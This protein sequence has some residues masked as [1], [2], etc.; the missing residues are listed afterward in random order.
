MPG[1]YIHMDVARKALDDLA[2]NASVAPIFSSQGTR[3]RPNP[4]HRAGQ[5][6]LRR[7]R[8]D[9][10][11]H[12]LPVARLQAAI[13]ADDMETRLHHY[14]SIPELGRHLPSALLMSDGADGN[15]AAN[16]ENALT[17]GLKDTI[18]TIVAE[19]S[20]LL[21]DFILNLILS[22]M[23]SSGCF[24]WPAGG[25][26]RADVLL[27]RHVPLSRDQPVRSRALATRQQPSD[28]SK[29]DRITAASR[30]SRW[31][32][33][34]HI[35]TDVTGHA[36]VNQKVGGPYR[37]HWQRHHLVENHLDSQVYSAEHGA[38]PI[39]DQMANAALHLWIA[40]NPDGSSRLNFFNSEPDFRR[41]RRAIAALISPAVTPCGTLI[42]TCP[43][44]SLTSSLTR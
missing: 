38:Q 14:G 12:L 34:L 15:D 40:F 43:I 18:E 23:T 21:H 5:P 19:A 1:W 17:G 13:R 22:S 25:I 3:R 29:P 10:A 8:R 30:L 36:F 20:S 11:R 42:P 6:G 24:Q 9:R 28:D 44:A 7:A 32:G 27:E 4:E 41:I 35:A 31:A 16:L 37:V 33:C 2:A 26:R 39:Y